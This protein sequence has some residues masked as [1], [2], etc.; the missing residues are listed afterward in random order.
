MISGIFIVL[1]F[2]LYLLWQILKRYS[3]IKPRIKFDI[4]PMIHIRNFDTLWSKTKEI[5]GQHQNEQTQADP[6]PIIQEL[7]DSIKTSFYDRPPF[8]SYLILIRE[9]FHSRFVVF[10]FTTEYIN[11]KY[12]LD[13]HFT[14]SSM[15][16]RDKPIIHITVTILEP[17]KPQTDD[18][19][20]KYAIVNLMDDISYVVKVGIEN[21]KKKY[22]INFNFND[23]TACLIFSK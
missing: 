2:L 16:E 13:F 15:I 4:D 3:P 20:N 10:N 5:I 6:S 21:F 12:Q 18:I 7:W 17:Y 14:R 22:T 1:G 9:N 19:W 11:V 8:K 23:S